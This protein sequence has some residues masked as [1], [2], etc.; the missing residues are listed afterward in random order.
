MHPQILQDHPGRCPICGMDLVE[1]ANHSEHE[2]QRGV[3]IDTASVQKLGVRLAGVTQT[4]LS[5]D[6]RSF[7]NVTT[8]GST[9]YDVYSKFDGVIKKTYIHSIGQQI[10][11]GQVIY[12]IYSR[13]L[14]MQQKE[15]LRFVERRNQILQSVGDVRFQEN[16]YVMNLL[17]E[18]SR[19][20]TRFLHQDISLETVQKI[21][22]SKMILEVVKIVAAES[23][24]VTQ[25]NA[26]D[27][28]AVTPAAALFTLANVS[29]VWVDVALYPDQVRQVQIGDEVTITN[30]DSQQIQARIS[31][32]NSVAQSNK[33]SARVTLDNRK[34]HLR[35]GSFVDVVIHAQPHEVL[36]IPRSAVMRTGKGNFVML[37]RGDGHFLPSPVQTG[38]ESGELIEISDGLRDAAQVAVNGQFL[39]DAASSLN[40]SMQRMQQATQ[41][42]NSD[43]EKQR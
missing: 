32:L 5:Q 30:F 38:V 41:I 3:Q 10:E 25:I 19:E 2:H 42:V 23:G 16:E 29:S 43:A 27:G 22:D 1:S 9:V 35:P 6:I 11:K 14:I 26:R 39:L 7:G 13:D 15:F 36:A 28:S 8:D 37:Y 17:T 18:F 31:F 40:D 21:E 24:S 33:V 34:L 12:E 20:R 4:T